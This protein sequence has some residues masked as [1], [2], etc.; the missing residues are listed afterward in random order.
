MPVTN[1]D[2]EASVWASPIVWRIWAKPYSDPSAAET[3]QSRRESPRS[4]RQKMTTMST[5]ARV[6]RTA[7]KSAGGTVCTRSRMRKNVDPHT[8]VSVTSRIVA[9]VRARAGDMAMRYA[10]PVR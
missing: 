3:S 7:R 4:W 5:A 10:A 9:T 1:P 6:N 8:A 2:T